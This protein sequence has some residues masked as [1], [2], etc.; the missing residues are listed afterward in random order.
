MSVPICFVRS[1][2]QNRSQIINDYRA[3]VDNHNDT[4]NRS[5]QYLNVYD[6]LWS[7]GFVLHNSRPEIKTQGKTLENLTYG[8]ANATDVFRKWASNLDFK[9]PN[10]G[11][12]EMGEV[13]WA[14]DFVVQVQALHPATHCIVNSSASCHLGIFHTLFIHLFVLAL[15]SYTG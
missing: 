12:R 9:S 13:K 3:R 7:I 15:K 5:N 11:V 1:I 6:A 10:I 14:C 4:S 8:D 2:L